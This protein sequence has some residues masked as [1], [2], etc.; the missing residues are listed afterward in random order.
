M[1]ILASPRRDGVYVFLPNMGDTGW[2]GPLVFRLIGHGLP[3]IRRRV[4][5]QD[6]ARDCPL[7]KPSFAFQ[8]LLGRYA[9]LDPV[10][11]LY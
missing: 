4:M 10:R 11:W 7:A 3:L 1:C 2:S 8:L 6:P 5:T 9:L